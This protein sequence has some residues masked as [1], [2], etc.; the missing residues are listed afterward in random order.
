MLRNKEESSHISHENYQIEKKIF[1]YYHNCLS[2]GLIDIYISEDTKILNSTQQYLQKLL[3]K[4]APGPRDCLSRSNS[5][6]TKYK[7]CRR[8]KRL[9]RTHG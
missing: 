2:K 1:N 3:M 8:P 5:N 7:I 6:G 9:C 4:N